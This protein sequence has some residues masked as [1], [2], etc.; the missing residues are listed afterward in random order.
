MKILKYFG[1]FL[2]IAGIFYAK[3]KI[4]QHNKNNI[5]VLDSLD[6]NR[7]YPPKIKKGSN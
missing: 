5:Q 6:D 4:D 2:A 7:D 1:M 3:S